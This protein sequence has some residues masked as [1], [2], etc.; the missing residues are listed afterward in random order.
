ME[1]QYASYSSEM[2]FLGNI[3]TLRWEIYNDSITRISKTRNH[4]GIP[5]IFVAL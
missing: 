1:I 4:T 5:H 3:I 2:T